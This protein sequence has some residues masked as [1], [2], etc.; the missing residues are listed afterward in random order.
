[1]RTYPKLVFLLPP[2]YLLPDIGFKEVLTN[3][4]SPDMTPPIDM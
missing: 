4:L 1:M 3:L 2:C